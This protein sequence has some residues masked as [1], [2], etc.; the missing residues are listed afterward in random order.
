[1]SR[2]AE[3]QECKQKKRKKC[4]AFFVVGT[5][6]VGACL[7]ALLH[8]FLLSLA[9]DHCTVLYLL[10][11]ILFPG[12]FQKPLELPGNTVVGKC[13]RSQIPT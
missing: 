8:V 6:I 11:P 3:N 7:V 4:E 1:M 5:S 13:V 12:D 9:A 2:Y 10:L